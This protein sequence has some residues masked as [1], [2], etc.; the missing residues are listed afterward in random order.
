MWLIARKQMIWL[1][2]IKAEFKLCHKL[3]PIGLIEPGQ[4]NETE[5]NLVV[6][7]QRS[8]YYYRAGKNERRN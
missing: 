1:G 6:L 2:N 8:A 4:K 3:G 5:V 7:N